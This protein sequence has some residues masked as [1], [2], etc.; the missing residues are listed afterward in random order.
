MSC[1]PVRF[2]MFEALPEHFPP[3]DILR[4]NTAIL[5]CLGGTLHLVDP[6]LVHIVVASLNVICDDVH[7]PE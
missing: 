4:I 1:L 2:D 6:K 7:L 3:F 5:E